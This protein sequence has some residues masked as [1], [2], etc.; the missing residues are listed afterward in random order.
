MNATV[1]LA[2][3]CATTIL[4]TMRV[5]RGGVPGGRRESTAAPAAHASPSGRP[6]C[7]LGAVA[8]GSPSPVVRDGLD[9]MED[10]FGILRRG[11]VL[12]EQVVDRGDEARPARGVH[13]TCGEPE[14]MVRRLERSHEPGGVDRRGTPRRADVELQAEYVAQRLETL[15]RRNPPAGASRG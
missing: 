1:A 14:P 2:G 6:G 8:R 5:H 4:R 10:A 12:A 15:D 7:A 13:R 3:W 9:E 11:V